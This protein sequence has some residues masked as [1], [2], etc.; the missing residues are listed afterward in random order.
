VAAGAP[1]RRQDQ[2]P[3][4][5][6]LTPRRHPFQYALATP[7][8]SATTTIARCRVDL[9]KGLLA[10]RNNDP[11]GG[12]GGRSR[13]TRIPTGRT[14]GRR[15]PNGRAAG[16]SWKVYSDQNGLNNYSMLGQCPEVQ[17]AAPGIRCGQGMKA[18][19]P[20]S[21]S[22]THCTTH[23]RRVV[24]H[25]AQRAVRHPAEPGAA[26][27]QG[28]RTLASKIARSRPIRR[29]EENRLHPRLRRERRPLRPRRTADP[30]RARTRVRDASGRGGFRVPCS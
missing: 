16:V 30:P 8:P 28:P 23:C 22:T 9:A 29:L 27:A 25:A 18:P 5:W 19:R 12:H 11:D 7:S 13:R 3:Y 21:S 14:G 15:T 10:D 17:H 4:V 1:G 2:R 6:V 20:G 24:A 26:P